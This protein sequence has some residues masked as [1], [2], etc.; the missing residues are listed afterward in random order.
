MKEGETL[1]SAVSTHWIKY[2]NKALFCHLL[3]LI[4]I[5]LLVIGA[6]IH[7]QLPFIGMSVVSLGAALILLSHHVLFHKLLSENMIDIIMTNERIIYF[8]DCLFT[9]N[10]EHEI[11]LDRIAGVEVQQRG[12]I[13]NLLGYGI[14]WFDTGGGSVD[15]KR[16]IPHVPHPDQLARIINDHV[17]SR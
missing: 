3:L 17:E 9:M 14:L 12:L 1:L 6:I 4:G 16:S 10:D 11:P 8:N 2:I 7:Q 13:P 15:L 5:L